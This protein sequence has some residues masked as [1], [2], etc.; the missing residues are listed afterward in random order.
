[1]RREWISPGNTIVAGAV[2][3]RGQLLLSQVTV[4]LL[5]PLSEETES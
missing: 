2:P 1:M 3:V 5:P 4:K